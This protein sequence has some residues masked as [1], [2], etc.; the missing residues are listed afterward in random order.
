MAAGYNAS[1]MFFFT[2]GERILIAL[3][4]A[5]LVGGGGALLY[6]RG[7]AAGAAREPFF[8]ESP[9]AARQGAALAVDVAGAVRKP[10][11]VTVPAGARMRDAIAKA[12]GFAENANPDALNLAAEVLDGQKIE[13]PSKEQAAASRESAAPR[14]RSSHQP[15]ALPKLKP[16]QTI[17]IN[18]ATAA[19][20]QRLP[21]VG[22]AY[23]QRIVAYRAELKR[24]TGSGFTATEQLMNIPGIGPKRYADLRPYLRL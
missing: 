16:G 8:V 4:L 19:Q 20:L 12:G 24:T 22:P 2:R 23:A 17:N 18:T 10:G 7:R 3:L 9:L 6:F 1:G 15:Q 11:V 21:G 14:P 5:A 13:V